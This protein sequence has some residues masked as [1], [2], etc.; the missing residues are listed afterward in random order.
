MSADR[1]DGRRSPFVN[2][3]DIFVVCKV[4]LVPV[5]NRQNAEITI[6]FVCLLAFAIQRGIL[7]AKTSHTDVY[8]AGKNASMLTRPCPHRLCFSLFH[9]I[10]AYLDHD[11]DYSQCDTSFDNGWPY[12]ALIQAAWIFHE[13]KV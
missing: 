13:Y 9:M 12:P 1:L 6:F 10:N 5:M 7:T 3:R 11:C 2:V 8:R 4:A